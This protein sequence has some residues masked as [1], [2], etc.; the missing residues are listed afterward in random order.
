[1]SL[2][3]CPQ[4]SDAVLR[5]WPLEGDAAP[6]LD[7]HQAQGMADLPSRRGANTECVRQTNRGDACIRLQRQLRL[8]EDRFIL[9]DL[10]IID[11]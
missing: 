6:L 3:D 5:S 4:G 11:L 2:R 9:I 10:A 8:G 7:A 1:M